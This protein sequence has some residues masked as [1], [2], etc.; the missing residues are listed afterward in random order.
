MLTRRGFVAA[1]SAT[2]LAS[3]AKFRGA[4]DPFTLGV[5]S[6]DPAPDGFV[7][8]TRLDP[9]GAMD[10]L[11]VDVAWEVADDERFARIVRAGTAVAR[12]EDAHAVHVEVAGLAPGRWYY[13]RFHAGVAES[14]TGRARTAPAPGAQVG[15][16]KIGVASCSDFQQGYFSAYRHMAAEAPDL[17]FFL[18]DYIYEFIEQR[19]AP[20]RR[21]SDGVEATDLRTYRN[22]YAQYRSDPDLQ[23]L[24]AAAPCLCTWDDHEVQNDYAERWAQ[25]FSDPAIFLKRREAAYRAYWEHMP[26]RLSARPRDGAVA[27]HRFVD[28]G[29]LARVW[30]LDGRQ[31]RSRPPC[32]AP[33][34]PVTKVINGNTCPEY[35]DPGRTML[36]AAQETW[37][38]RNLRARRARWNLFGQGVIM[39]E[40]VQANRQ[41]VVGHWSDAW[42]GHPAARDRFLSGL[43]ETR[44]G[45]PI[46]LSGDIHSFFANELKLDFR[47]ARAAPIASE[48]V[49]TSITS[50]GVPYEPFAG[51]AARMPH[52]KYFESRHRGYLTLEVA[53]SHTV[54]AMRAIS[55][56][57]DPNATVSTLKRFAVENGKSGPVAA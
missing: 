42:S 38:A 49:V 24:H 7:I 22:R 47:D 45:N 14:R 44:A 40:F 52:M 27:L 53:P 25:D 21:H 33:G 6:G 31:Y 16:F 56:V 34:T 1:A 39:A 37:L 19:W 8:W 23:A 18:G 48:F 29:A 50:P 41:G 36:G 17:V 35:L 12:P 2:L 30:I 28:W 3:C 32:Y 10:P 51:W 20:V 11:P 4:S 57:R 54:A 15:S 55:D 9:A 46:V 26:L 13:Y 5:A 43:A